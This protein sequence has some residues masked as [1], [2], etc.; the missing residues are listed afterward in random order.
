MKFVGIAMLWIGFVVGSLATVMNSEAKGVKFV[1]KLNAEDAEKGGFELPDLS[2]VEIPEDG[3]HLIP[4]SWYIPSAIVCLVGAGL[5]QIANRSHGQKSDKTEASLEEIKDSLNRL[6][7]QTSTLGNAMLKLPPSKIVERI[8][9]ELAD[10]LRAFADGRESIVAEFGLDCFADVMTNFAAGERAINRAWSAAADGYVDEAKT[11]ID[12][13][14][15]LL[16]EASNE[17]KTAGKYGA[18]I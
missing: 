10:D 15:N 6:C 17:L 4:W 16:Q 11:C 1:K 7:E 8:D 5:I 13:A 14:A 18:D 2:G 9:D 3:W 12:R